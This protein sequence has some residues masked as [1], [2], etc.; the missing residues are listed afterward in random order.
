[1]RNWH[2]RAGRKQRVKIQ[3]LISEKLKLDAAT[4]TIERAHCTGKLD[5][6]SDRQQPT[7]VKFLNFKDKELILKKAKELR[8]SAPGVYINEDF[9]DAVRE[10]RKELLPKL[11]EARDRG[12]IAYLRYDQLVAHPPRKRGGPLPCTSTPNRR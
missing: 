6:G 4:I 9:S 10:I 2:E 7:A 1:M 8:I 3:S 12:N 11:K 5:P